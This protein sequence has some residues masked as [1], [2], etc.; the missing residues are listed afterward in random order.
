M[1]NIQTTFENG[2]LEDVDIHFQIMNEIKTNNS[3]IETF[4]HVLSVSGSL[5]SL[6]GILGMNFQFLFFLCFFLLF[7]LI[8]SFFL[9]QGNL[10]SLFILFKP[11]SMAL[12]FSKLNSY[13][14][15]KPARKNLG[16][17]EYKLASFYAYL[18]A[19]SLC[20]FF[21]CI[22]AILNILQYMVVYILLMFNWCWCLFCLQE[23]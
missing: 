16:S 3:R 23:K 6:F 17:F 21:S 5:I 18:K 22:F 15:N 12:T 13:K 11:G 7:W 9:S 20:D 1:H 19:L 14:I 4:H 10:I 8:F 2:S